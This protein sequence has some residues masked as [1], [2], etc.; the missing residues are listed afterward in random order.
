MIERRS[1]QKMNLDDANEVLGIYDSRENYDVTIGITDGS[2]DGFFQSTVGNSLQ[3]TAG[4]ELVPNTNITIGAIKDEST[5]RIFIFNY[6]PTAANN[7]I[8]CYNKSANTIVVVIKG[9]GLGFTR[10]RVRGGYCNGNLV[11]CDGNINNPPR[12]LHVGTNPN[13]LIIY[14]SIIPENIDLC[15]APPPNVCSYVF[16]NDLGITA[17]NNFIKNWS[18]QFAARFVFSNGM[19][20]KTNYITDLAVGVFYNNPDLLVPTVANTITVTCGSLTTGSAY[21]QV[22][23][24]IEFLVRDFYTLSFKSI[25]KVAYPTSGTSASI[26]FTNSDVYPTVSL[27]D[28]DLGYDAVPLSVNSIAISDSRVL[29]ANYAEG[30]NKMSLKFNVSNDAPFLFNELGV[31]ITTDRVKIQKPGSKYKLALNFYDDKQRRGLSYTY[32][33]FAYKNDTQVTSVLYRYTHEFVL[34]NPSTNIPSWVKKI[35]VAISENL[36][37]SW[38]I[39]ARIE[40][41]YYVTGRDINGTP[42]FTKRIGAVYDLFNTPSDDYVKTEEAANQYQLSQIYLDQFNYTSKINTTSDYSQASEVWIDISN[43][44]RYNNNV[45]YIF[46]QGDR[47]RLLTLGTST[48]ADNEFD[49]AI[50]EQNGRF[51]VIDSEL[52]EMNGI[53]TYDFGD[54]ITQK[55]LTVAVN[56]KGQIFYNKSDS[57]PYT[58][59]INLPASLNKVAIQQRDTADPIVVVVGDNGKMYHSKYSTITTWTEATTGTDLNINNICWYEQ[60][61]VDPTL[62]K[63]FFFC[64]SGGL[65][66]LVDGIGFTFQLYGTQA[67]SVGIDSSW[68]LVGLD[69][70]PQSD[71][72]GNTIYIAIS[73]RTNSGG[74]CANV[75]AEGSRIDSAS[76]IFYPL[77][78]NG[79]SANYNDCLLIRS[80]EA[81]TLNIVQAGLGFDGTGSID[82][83]AFNYVNMPRSHLYSKNIEKAKSDTFGEITACA[84]QRSLELLPS[85]DYYQ[86]LFFATVDGKVLVR[87]IEYKGTY[88]GN[89]KFTPIV[90]KSQT[91]QSGFEYKDPII[92]GYPIFQIYTPYDNIDDVITARDRF[93][94]GYA[95]S[96]TITISANSFI[97]GGSR[98]N[99]IS[100]SKD[101]R[102][103][104]I[105]LRRLIQT[106]GA[107][108]GVSN[109]LN[110]GNGGSPLTEGKITPFQ[111]TIPYPV[112][113]YGA[114]IEIYSPKKANST[115]Q[116]YES[117]LSTQTADTRYFDNFSGSKVITIGGST[118]GDCFVVEKNYKGRL[119]SSNGFLVSMTPYSDDITGSFQNTDKPNEYDFGWIKSN[120]RPNLQFVQDPK[121]IVYENRVCFGQKSIQST[122]INNLNTFNP[123]DFKDFSSDFGAIT[124][125]VNTTDVQNANTILL[126]VCETDMISVYLNSVQYKDAVGGSTVSVSEQVL[127]SFNVL[128]KGIGSVSHESIAEKD[129]KVFGYDMINGVMW[130]YDNNGLDDFQNK[131]MYKY[132]QKKGDLYRANKLANGDIYNNIGFIDPYHKHYL[133]FFDIANEL[134]AYDYNR[135]GYSSFFRYIPECAIDFNTLLI[136]FK[137]GL[138]YVHNTWLPNTY[139][140]SYKGKSTTKIV[141]NQNPT[142]KKD[143]QA[144]RSEGD[145]TVATT[146]RTN[147]IGLPQQECNQ[148]EA[149][150]INIEGSWH[151][152]ILKDKN[153]FGYVDA[154]DATLNGDAMSGTSIE[155]TNEFGDGTNIK[156]IKAVSVLYVPSYG[157]KMQ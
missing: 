62:D 4:S 137:N 144:H 146:I 106:V 10:N 33:Q 43:L 41:A 82:V 46:T 116:Y 99:D 50:K 29:C 132:F 101:R 6:D 102:A 32:N 114:L 105:P 30:Q 59:A 103:A 2:N 26:V 8:L 81:N 16:S 120:A 100:I 104:N 126:I 5:N 73:C 67:T 47:L 78:S 156:T 7:Q 109:I 34:S 127:G 77:E 20:S 56:K 152:N 148:L 86:I 48:N 11:W 136:T 58:L 24:S 22:I 25:G 124:K 63:S 143:Y 95:N 149:D 15:K 39:Q 85:T 21:T 153:S 112:L 142:L 91:I 9:A 70:L 92:Y 17:A 36:T 128:K 45:P 151:A 49:Y 71:L 131:K 69:V 138:P 42:R 130:Q 60:G 108:F 134:V 13:S 93:N 64:G 133:I 55:R 96:E 65:L 35:S 28:T 150:Y 125:I 117:V 40:H 44:T 135:L 155:V 66:G 23:S 145:L 74:K 52:S 68:E 51:L 1:V 38:F 79:T 37:V 76:M 122:L 141:F 61:T 118:D 129:G 147:M 72:L 57:T 31:A 157:M 115:V 27:D 140:G 83:Y 53:D 75:M 97:N 88:S 3:I 121:Q 90:S 98:L 139:Y 89:V 123:L 84:K 18:G 107:F 113:N 119:W 110:N 19:V 80:N 94:T 54:G 14:G 111:T 154:A 87:G 12:S